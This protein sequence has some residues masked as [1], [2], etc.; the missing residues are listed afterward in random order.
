MREL[1]P[2]TWIPCP[3]LMYDICLDFYTF[4]YDVRLLSIGG[5]L[6]SDEKY[7]RLYLGDGITGIGIEALKRKKGGIRII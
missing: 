4:L 5:L 1:P 6:F 2:S 7:G 3:A